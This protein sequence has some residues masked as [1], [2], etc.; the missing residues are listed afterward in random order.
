LFAHDVQQARHFPEVLSEIRKLEEAQRSVAL[1]RS[2]LQL[3]VK[4]DFVS[5]MKN[6]ID[7]KSFHE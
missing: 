7:D 4:D 5:I 2:H 3:A 6:L 1:Y